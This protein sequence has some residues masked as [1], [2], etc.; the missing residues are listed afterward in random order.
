MAVSL[1]VL[2]ASDAL[3]SILASFCMSS[4]F[5]CARSPL[6]FPVQLSVT[7]ANASTKTKLSRVLVIMTFHWPPRP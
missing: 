5:C 3:L 2:P 1:S 7:I 4:P 6:S